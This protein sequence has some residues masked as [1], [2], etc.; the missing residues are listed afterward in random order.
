LPR[1]DST[2]CYKTLFGKNYDG[3]TDLALTL[4]VLCEQ[5]VMPAVDIPLPEYDRWRTEAGCF[6][7]DLGI[8]YVHPR[9]SDLVI[10][11]NTDVAEAVRGDLAD[12]IVESILQPV[13]SMTWEQVLRDARHELLLARENDCP[14]FCSSGRRRLIQ[15]L[16]KQGGADQCY[17]AEPPVSDNP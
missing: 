10:E 7:K 15:R 4:S 5:L 6:D 13:P 12:P 2:A 17:I 14:I 3:F 8:A 16:L 11:R 9:D 1:L